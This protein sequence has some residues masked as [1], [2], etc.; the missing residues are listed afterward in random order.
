MLRL[1]TIINKE[2]KDKYSKK[3]GVS[4]RK[5]KRQV[6]SPEKMLNQSRDSHQRSDIAKITDGNY[7]ESMTISPSKFRNNENNNSDANDEDYEE[8]LPEQDL[9]ES[10]SMTERLDDVKDNINKNIEQV[11]FRLKEVS[12]NCDSLNNKI[13]EI[14]KYVKEENNSRS[15]EIYNLVTEI[16]EIR[17]DRLSA[18]TQTQIGRFNSIARENYFINSKNSK[19]L[20]IYSDDLKSVS[21][22]KEPK[23]RASYT[24]LIPNTAKTSDLQRK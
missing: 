19:D 8:E 11:K 13:N 16:Q 5:T 23:E 7:R 22:S 15:A 18:F 1:K 21:K 20:I 10:I 3:T 6:N 9:D 17:T 2:Q 24:N 14:S 4:N 12:N